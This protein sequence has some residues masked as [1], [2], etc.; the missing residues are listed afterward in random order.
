MLEREELPTA[1]V[2]AHFRQLGDQLG[3]LVNDH[4]ELAR[5]EL[6]QTVTR[7]GRDVALTAVGVLLLAIGYALLAVAASVALGEVIGLARGFLIVS[8]FH[9]V[10][11]LTL[12]MVFARR[13]QRQDKPA[14]PDTTAALAEDGRFARGLKTQLT[15]H[16]G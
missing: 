10:V 3:K 12:T 7:A 8:A 1:Q 14:L 13:L 2:G 5:A 9:V 4:V 6:R 16:R 11:G 15:Q